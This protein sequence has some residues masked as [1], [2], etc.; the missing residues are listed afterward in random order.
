[1]GILDRGAL[2][3]RRQAA[4]PVLA[5]YL[6][7]LAQRAR[8]ADA[9]AD[10]RRLDVHFGRVTPADPFAGIGDD[11]IAAMVGATGAPRRML[12]AADYNKSIDDMLPSGPEEPFADVLRRN[13]RTRALVNSRL[14]RLTPDEQ[15]GSL[16]LV[17]RQA[18]ADARVRRRQDIESDMPLS[19]RAGLTAGG[20]LAATA[21]AMK[22]QQ[23][24]A[25]AARAKQA[26]ADEERQYRMDLDTALAGDAD[27]AMPMTIDIGEDSPISGFD[28]L[29][30]MAAAV[31][32]PDVEMDDATRAFVRQFRKKYGGQQEAD[33]QGLMAEEPTMDITPDSP[34]EAA[35]NAPGPATPVG[36]NRDLEDLPAPQMRSVRALMRAGIPEGRAMAIIVKGSAMSPDE[37]RMVT[38]GRR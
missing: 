33:V 20:V 14:D 26:A 1:M 13:D 16:G 9:A 38:G 30:E 23:D 32:V 6:D 4:N 22:A 15:P 19:V 18:D 27:G 36:M 34:D 7:D 35:S 2:A 5:R 37:Y 29:A 17:G 31:P 12:E 3:A 21:A 11:P 8:L 24:A 25:A 10:A 28:P